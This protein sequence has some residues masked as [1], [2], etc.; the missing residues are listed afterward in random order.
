MKVRESANLMPSRP[1]ALNAIVLGYDCTVREC[2]CRPRPYEFIWEYFAC[3]LRNMELSFLFFDPRLADLDGSRTGGG[4][5]FV[6]VL[7]FFRHQHLSSETFRLVDCVAEPRMVGLFA[8]V[9][10]T[11]DLLQNT[12]KHILNAASNC[13][14]FLSLR[15]FGPR[16]VVHLSILP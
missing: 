9:V 5:H 12:L 3:L 10:V 13:A 8:R 11:S 15:C 1:R 2:L 4:R 7:R 16:Q 14:F 6:V